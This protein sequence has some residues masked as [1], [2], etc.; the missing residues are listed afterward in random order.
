MTCSS[1]AGCWGLNTDRSVNGLINSVCQF[2]HGER[3][4]VNDMA[5][6]QPVQVLAEALTKKDIRKKL[7]QL[8]EEEDGVTRLD[9]QNRHCM[10][11]LRTK[12]RQI[13][14]EISRNGGEK[15]QR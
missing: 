5:C 4:T 9:E 8:Q 1:W 11:N 15:V 6:Q 10:A 7:L 2:E 3:C 13:N 12:V 14:N